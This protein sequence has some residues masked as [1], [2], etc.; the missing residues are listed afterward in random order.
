MTA[1][2]DPRFLCWE[3]RTEG[4]LEKNAQ[5]TKRGAGQY[6]TPRKGICPLASKADIGRGEIVPVLSIAALHERS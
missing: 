6:F 4:P 1:E 2:V 5:D 3:T